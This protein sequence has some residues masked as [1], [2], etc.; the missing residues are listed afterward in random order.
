MAENG[1]EEQLPLLPVP[2]QS[3]RASEAAGPLRGPPLLQGLRPVLSLGWCGR[4]GS[5]CPD[6]LEGQDQTLFTHFS[7]RD[8]VRTVVT[9]H[10]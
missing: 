7:F 10:L 3:M 5:Y 2:G 9:E 8:S 6:V 4:E 1:E